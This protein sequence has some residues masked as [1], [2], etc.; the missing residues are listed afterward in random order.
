VEAVHEIWE[1]GRFDEVIVTTHPGATS[2]WLTFD[3]RTAWRASPT[4]ASRA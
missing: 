2:K 1:P 4:P 3:S